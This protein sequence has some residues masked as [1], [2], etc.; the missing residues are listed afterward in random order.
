[1]IAEQENPWAAGWREA[2]A[3]AKDMT[4]AEWCAEYVYL[5][6]SPI[7]AK[8]QPGSFCDDILNDL[9]DP[10]V[11][12]SAVVGHTGMGKS[13]ILES[14]SCWIV[15]EAPGPTLVLGQTNKTVQEWMET[16]LNKAFALC[17][18]VRRLL[19]SGKDRHDKKKTAVLFRHMEYLTGGANLTNTQE[20]S[21]RYTL[22]DE[23]WEWDPGIIGE[24]LKRH[25]DRWNRKS[26]LVAQGGVEDDDWDRH[27]RDGLGFDRAFRCPACGQGQI[28][29]WGNV[30]YDSATDGNGDWDWTAIFPTV[31][32]ECGNEDCGEKFPDT[33]RGRQRLTSDP[34]FECRHNSHIPG[35]VTRYIP[36]MA[37]PR[38]QLSSL[39]KEWLLAET[40]WKQGN[41]V[42]RRQFI[43]KRL[44]Q[45]WEEKP[46]VPTLD[47][48]SDPYQKSQYNEGEKWEE[49]HARMMLIDVQKVGFWVVI[50][51][52]KVGEVRARLL[53]EGQVDTWQTLFSLQERFGLENRDV[54][55]DGA[56]KVDEV[57]RQ[58]VGHCGHDVAGHWSLMMGMDNEKGYQFSV[59]PAKRQRKVWKIY[60]K[61]QHGT[62][63]HG[64]RYRM[65]HFSNLRAKD[66]LAG[67]ME[68][69]GMF[70][71]PTD[72]SATYVAQMKSETKRE[73]K[74]GKWRWEKVKDHYHNHLWD[75]EVMGVVACAIRG[76][77]KVEMAEQQP[78]H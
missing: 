60:S 35:R 9:Q 71:V 37:N 2:H 3:P 45:F 63:S 54:F 67:I 10:E 15:S 33:P 43:Q 17:E 51:A 6:N 78:S 69:P 66:A 29:K 21:M 62:T 19:P 68:V 16:R 77:L 27:A 1:M 5:A 52:W 8:Y 36:A 7:G 30:R 64:L 13:A 74:P 39:V 76:I 18:P 46:E 57:V 58:I 42:P 73:V 40:A 25:H 14:A 31:R 72:C 56:Y 53:W 47:T 12:E 49:E 4:V 38:I 59:G 34:Y 48:G 23:P 22:G 20:K 32:Y 24:L 28:F 41:K 61:W 44:A 26:L 11:Y 65:I 50:R 75:C 55:I 70:G